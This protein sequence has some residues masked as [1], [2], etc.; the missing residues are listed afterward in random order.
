MANVSLLADLSTFPIDRQDLFDMWATAALD[1]LDEADFAED[2]SFLKVGSCLSDAPV[3]PAPGQ[4]FWSLCEGLLYCWFDQVDST[5]VSLWLS[6]GPDRFDVPALTGAPVGQAHPVD[7][8]YDKWVVVPTEAHQCPLGFSAQGIVNPAELN[9]GEL[10]VNAL[11]SEVTEWGAVTAASGTWIRVSVD[12]I[13][14][15]CT[16][17]PSSH[18][19]QGLV[20]WDNSA[21]LSMDPTNPVSLIDAAS[22]NTPQRNVVGM[23]V[24]ELPFS[25]DTGTA[26]EPVYTFRFQFQPRVLTPFL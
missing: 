5:G 25:P 16:L 14:Y 11:G 18:L 1:L 10:R 17:N 23:A 6:V 7:I 8:L 20:A 21:P 2:V 3:A 15:G 19:S 22:W 13:V 12:G 4:L 24:H 9:V 26:S